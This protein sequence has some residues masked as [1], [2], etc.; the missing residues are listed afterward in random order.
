MQ[1]PIKKAAPSQAAFGNT[2]PQYTKE[3]SILIA[4]E[5]GQTINRFEAERMGDHCLNSTVS[6]LRAK[7]HDIRDI[8]ERV[9]TRFGRKVRVKRYFL[10]QK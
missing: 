4:F 3:I 7:G 9:P 8:W 10:N 2:R 5:A 1:T 6:N